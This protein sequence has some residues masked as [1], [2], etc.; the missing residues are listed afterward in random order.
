MAGFQVTTEVA[1]KAD[2]GGK[3]RLVRSGSKLTGLFHNGS[4]FV[5]LGNTTVL[6]NAARF[7]LVVGSNYP[8]GGAVHVAFDNF[9]VNASTITCPP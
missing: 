7:V 3:L 6:T 1:V 2:T 8:G 4:M 9:K 5:P